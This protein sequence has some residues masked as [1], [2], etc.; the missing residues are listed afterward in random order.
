MILYLDYNATAPVHPKVLDEMVRVY[1]EEFGNA[2]SRTHAYGQRADEIVGRSRSQ[3]ATLLGIHG[4]ELIFTSGATES[5]NLA[6]VGLAPWGAEH[7]RR[8]IISTTIEHK[9][10]LEP[11]AYLERLGFEVEL[12]PVGSSGRVDASALLDRVRSDTL[13]VTMLH[14]NNETGILQ[15]VAEIGEALAR[16]PVFFHVDAAQT[17]GKEVESLRELGYDLL[18]IT[19]HKI[20]GPQGI[21]GLVLKEHR[22]GHR[23]AV[24]TTHVRWWARARTS[25]RHSSSRIDS[26]IRGCG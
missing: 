14:A 24:A 20:Q 12:V 25:T 11:L 1:R 3:I 7:G 13:L 17:I 8:H 21:G 26:R 19:A 6:L 9:A 16:T 15:P 18:S 5:N 4:R 22:Q 2:G 10:I 23:T